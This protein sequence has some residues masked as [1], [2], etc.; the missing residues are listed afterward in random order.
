MYKCLNGSAPK[1]LSD[2]LIKSTANR[3]GLLSSN[4]GEKFLVPFNKNKTFADRS[5]GTAGPLL[6]NDLPN[7]VKNCANI[8]LFKKRLKT[9]LF[10]EAF[11]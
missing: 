11:L 3:E 10:V 7:N 5:F 1:Y 9:E 8:E 4:N 6:W 2:L